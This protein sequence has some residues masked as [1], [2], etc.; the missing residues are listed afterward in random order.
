MTQQVRQF[1]EHCRRLLATG[2]K[3]EPKRFRV[4]NQTRDTLLA[5]NIEVADSD[6]KRTKGLLGRKSLPPQGGLWIVPC[7][8]VHSFGMQFPIDLV[9]LD[10]AYRVNKVR[11]NLKPWKISACFTAH[12]VLEL[13]VGAIERSR[14]QL[15][16][17]LEF[18][19]VT[20][21]DYCA[22]T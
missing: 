5:A 20:A 10:R 14:T 13:P 11:E 21:S 6:G 3:P 2:P 7:E 19:P 15:G 1:L 16:D 18:L 9:Y 4:V 17:S 22:D 12:S 8:A